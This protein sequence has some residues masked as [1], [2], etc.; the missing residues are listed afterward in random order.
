MVISLRY[1]HGNESTHVDTASR[2]SA[3]FSGGRGHLGH[4]IFDLSLSNP[5]RDDLSEIRM[6]LLPK[7]IQIVAL[8]FSVN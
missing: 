2:S 4:V 7:D 6:D 5:G 1:G 8:F 3:D